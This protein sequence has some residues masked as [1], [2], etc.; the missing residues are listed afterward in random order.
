MSRDL[1]TIEF[2]PNVEPRPFESPPLAGKTWSPNANG[3]KV[4]ALRFRL[5]RFDEI[6][7]DFGA[8]YL[9]KGLLPREG[10]AV[11]WGP[12][13]CGKSFLVADLLLHVAFGW[14]YRGHRVA[15]GAVV[16]C[17][18]EGVHGFR[19]RLQAVRMA[20]LRVGCDAA[21]PFFLMTASLSLAA[22]RKR[23]IDDIKLQL[24]NIKPVA[25]CIDTLNRSIGGSENDDEAMSN[26]VRA[27][28]AIR[29]AF[30]CL[31]VIVHHCGH[32]GDRPRGHSSL[33]GALD[34]QISVKRDSADNIVAELELS[35]DGP[36]GLQL[37]SRLKVV[38]IGL[39]EDGEAITSCVVE[40]VGTGAR[41][42]MA[43]P[44]RRLPKGAAIALAALQKAIEDVGEVSAASNHIPA[45]VRVVTVEKWRTYAYQSGISDTDDADARRMAFRRAHETLIGGQHVSA[46]EEFRWLA[47]Q[48]GGRTRTLNTP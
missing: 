23:L 19:N 35:K 32:G 21:T 4:A 40:A 15:Q 6:K 9:V 36:I 11:V 3:I 47:G 18:L 28:N 48:G 16:Y 39:D 25:V 34:T 37:V 45:G 17:G 24:G 27:A 22:D 2:K 12:P 46:W 13:K 43:K 42:S 26:Y 41:S 5:A 14:E 30:D 31:V 38:E 29:E 20:K 44:N 10:L 33:I 7:P 1:E 8:R